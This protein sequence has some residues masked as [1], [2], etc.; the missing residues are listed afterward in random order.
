MGESQ[1]YFASPEDAA[2]CDELTHLLVTQKAAFNSPVW[3]NVV[4]RHIHNAQ[5]ALSVS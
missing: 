1:N 5:P 4:W 2:F 3:F